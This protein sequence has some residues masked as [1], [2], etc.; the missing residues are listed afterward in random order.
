MWIVVV[1]ET[2][3]ISIHIDR[4]REHQSRSRVSDQ[5]HRRLCVPHDKYHTTDTTFHYHTFYKET[6]NHWGF[7]TGKVKLSSWYWWWSFILLLPLLPLIIYWFY[8]ITF[9]RHKMYAY[10]MRV[11]FKFSRVALLSILSLF[12]LHI[13]NSISDS[14]FADVWLPICICHQSLYQPF[15]Y[16]L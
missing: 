9:E 3:F 13:F 16:D 4:C 14:R 8:L 15:K 12:S 2:S 7:T 1:F 6:P 10:H 5:S 11:L